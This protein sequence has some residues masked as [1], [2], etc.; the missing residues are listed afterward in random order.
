MKKSEFKASI[1]EEIIEI[2]SEESADDIKAKA[3]AQAE[4]NKEL[5]KT[6]S[7]Q[8]EDDSK[9]RFTQKEIDD[10]IA[11]AVR[12]G[13]KEGP[14]RKLASL[15]IGRKKAIFDGLN[16]VYQ[17]RS[18]MEQIVDLFQDMMGDEYDGVPYTK[19]LGR[20]VKFI[21]D[22]YK[23]AEREGEKFSD[24]PGFEGT[25]DALDNISIKEEDDDDAEMDRKASK[26]A[27]KGDSVSK[28]AA[29][30][31][32]TTKEMKQVVKKWKDSEGAEKAKLT[33]RL[34]ELTKIK[35]EIESLL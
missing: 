15:N 26:A 31:Q 4:L 29:K 27:K 23:A 21:D 34:K 9:E 22:D 16:E 32:Q 25:R 2:L 11:Q 17:T 28:L 10:I 14:L 30:L 6:A 3:S 13:A 19:V 24:I 1:K 12:A 7:L 18:K 35:K 5:E 20:L 33:D 8:K